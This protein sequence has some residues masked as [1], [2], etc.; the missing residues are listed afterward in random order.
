MIN[1]NIDRRPKESILSALLSI[2]SKIVPIARKP[3]T[4]VLEYGGKKWMD[5]ASK[6]EIEKVKSILELT[7]KIKPER[8]SR[9][10]DIS[11]ELETLKLVYDENN[12]WSYIN[13]LN[14]NYSDLAVFICD[15]LEECTNKDI[16]IIYKG[17]KSIPNPDLN[18]LAEI[19]NMVPDHTEYIWNKFLSNPDKYTQNTRKNTQEGDIIEDCA[20]KFYEDD[21][22]EIIHRGGNGN[23][24]D[25]KLGVDI[26]VKKDDDY[27][28]VQVKKVP[29]ISEVEID[30]KFYTQVNGSF[31]E[32]RE[33]FI[34][35]IVY[36]TLD[37]K[38]CKVNKQNYFYQYNNEFL[39]SFGFP[40]PHKSNGNKIFIEK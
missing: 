30:S 21:G 37:G 12:N 20:V 15:L 39:S 3:M 18:N 6:E 33:T 17:I 27:R 22:W 28:F 25:M 7:K 5:V 31:Y 19:M 23:I 13:K 16:N 35:E 14:T 36:G 11:K 8:S 24:I 1:Y 26:I 38:L 32:M 9:I 2:G 40:I 29:S 4:L 10:D 34:D